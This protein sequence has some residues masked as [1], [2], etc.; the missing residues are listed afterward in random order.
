[1]VLGASTKWG[2]GRRRAI[3]RWLAVEHRYAPPLDLGFITI[4][5][6]TIYSRDVVVGFH[7]I[8]AALTLA[9]LMLPFRSFVIRLALWMTV[10]VALVVWGISSLDV[11]SAELSELPI[12]T[13]VLILIFL[14]AQ[15][16]SQ[17][18]AES[19]AATAELQRRTDLQQA[20]LREQLEQGQ[21]RELLG[22]ASAGLAHDLRNIFMVIR[23]SVAEVLERADS[24]LAPGTTSTATARDLIDVDSATDRGLSIVDELLWLGRQHDS[25]RE[26]TDLHTATRQLEP[27]LRR[28]TRRGVALRLEVPHDECMVRIDRVGLSQILMNLVSNANDAITGSGMITV[29]TKRSLTPVGNGTQLTS[30]LT[31]AD[32]GCGFSPE[33]L[34][35]ALDEGVTSKDDTHYGL[36]LATVW[37]IVDR[38][39]GSLQIDSSPGIGTNVSIGFVNPTAEWPG[40]EVGQRVDDAT[41][42]SP[43]ASPTECR[44]PSPAGGRREFHRVSG[45]RRP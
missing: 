1:M 6:V 4:T 20:S 16:R 30:V 27:L 11:P 34:A 32:T 29:S 28:L 5:L 17:A 42:T 41:A 35:A 7:T 25:T 12:L 15:A 24:G 36:G 22:R 14:V 3:K 19:A 9:A 21:R 10:T 43:P 8:F 44:G 31:V 26:L 40:P 13:F 2:D 23:G 18:A 39:G 37:R 38:Y 45:R 33:A